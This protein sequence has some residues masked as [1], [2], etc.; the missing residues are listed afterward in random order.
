VYDTQRVVRILGLDGKES[1]A[2]L[3][4]EMGEPHAELE[5]ADDEV[6]EAFNPN[7]GRYDVAID[8]G[9]SYQTQRQEAADALTGLTQANPQLMQVAG[10]LVVSSFDFPMADALATRLAKALPPEL[11]D[12]KGQQGQIPPQVQQALQQAAQEIQQLQQALQEAQSGMAVKQL[13]VQSRER[14]AAAADETKRYVADTTND[15]RHDIAELAGMVQLLAKQIQPPADL[16]S[17]VSADLSDTSGEVS[18][19]SQ[20]L[21]PTSGEAG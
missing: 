10:D 16:S 14:I 7:V 1:A 2:V 13:E 15:V 8:T 3:N 18:A 6:K 5:T 4:P 21:Q 19:H 17:E 20:D 12:D 11:Q 9:P